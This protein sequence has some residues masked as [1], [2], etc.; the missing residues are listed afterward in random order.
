MICNN[1][2]VKQIVSGSCDFPL[3]EAEVL[4]SIKCSA[5]GSGHLLPNALQKQPILIYILPRAILNSPDSLNCLEEDA[6][7]R[8]LR[9]VNLNPAGAELFFNV[10][11]LLCHKS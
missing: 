4:S 5:V 6:M 8:K 1:L 11:N 3:T 10:I 9:K 2:H 7:L